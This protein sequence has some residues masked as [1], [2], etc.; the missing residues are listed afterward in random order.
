MFNMVELRAKAEELLDLLR[1]LIH[2]I[3]GLRDELHHQKTTTGG[4]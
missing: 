3:R 2:E 4:S 1:E